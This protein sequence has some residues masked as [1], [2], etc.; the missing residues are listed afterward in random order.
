MFQTAYTAALR[1]YRSGAWYPNA[2]IYSGA[3][4]HMQFTSLQAF[5]PGE[6]EPGEFR[7]LR[8]NLF[9]T[10]G[11]SLFHRSGLPFFPACIV[12]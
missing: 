8:R 4:T 1:H 3:L 5:W 6:S 12:S 11:I 2:D 7:A 9:V 10:L